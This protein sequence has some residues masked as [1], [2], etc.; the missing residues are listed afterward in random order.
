MKTLPT[1]NNVLLELQTEQTTEAGIIIQTTKQ[2][3]RATVK[4]I[5]DKVT[6]IKVGQTV[7]YQEIGAVKFD[8]SGR[9]HMILEDINIKAIIK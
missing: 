5:G 3:N 8:E 4:A 9:R 7:I 1:R 2:S 6:D